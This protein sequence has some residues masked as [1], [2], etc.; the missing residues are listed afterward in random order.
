[1]DLELMEEVFA[2]DKGVDIVCIEDYGSHGMAEI[3][4]VRTAEWVEEMV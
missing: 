3:V 4:K 1:M 2:G